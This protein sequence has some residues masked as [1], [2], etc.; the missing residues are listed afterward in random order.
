[1]DYWS[2][3]LQ[4]RWMQS[5]DYQN[6]QVGLNNH[7]IETED[8]RYRIIVSAQQPETGNWIDTAGTREGLLAIRYQLSQDSPPPTLSLLKFS[9]L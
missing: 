6:Y 3:S 1:M 2:V 9:E 8:G 5:L 7:Q 4:N